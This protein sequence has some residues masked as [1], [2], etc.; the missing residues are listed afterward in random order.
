[1]PVNSTHPDCDANLIA[2]RRARK[3]ENPS[4]YFFTFLTVAERQGAS[5]TVSRRQGRASGFGGAKS[6]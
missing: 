1:M 5:A 2:W 3:I 4:N 6:P